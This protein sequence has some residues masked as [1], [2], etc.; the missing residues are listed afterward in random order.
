MVTGRFG[1]A[2][3]GLDVEDRHILAYHFGGHQSVEGYSVDHMSVPVERLLK[4]T[5]VVRKGSFFPDAARPFRRIEKK[6]D[7]DP[8]TESGRKRKSRKIW[9][10]QTAASS[11]DHLSMFGEVDAINVNS[12]PK[13]QDE[14]LGKAA[15][16]SSLSGAETN[17]SDSSGQSE[18]TDEGESTE[19]SGDEALVKAYRDNSTRTDG[20]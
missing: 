17:D 7:N 18:G 12:D 6:Q 3:F 15:S 20:F 8:E 16:D 19:E 13:K 11:E 10:E 2:Q 14:V 4:V 5:A 1:F 9:S